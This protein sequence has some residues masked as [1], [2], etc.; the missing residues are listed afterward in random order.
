M[1]AGAI[2]R[3]QVVAGVKHE[4]S[5]DVRL[6][7]YW[8]SPGNLTNVEYEARWFAD[9]EDAQPKIEKSFTGLELAE[10]LFEPKVFKGEVNKNP[11]YE[12]HKNVCSYVAINM[13]IQRSTKSLITW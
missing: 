4:D 5:E 6:K 1:N 12:F 10:F 3:V 11:G 13:H 9:D 2:P 7:C 8:E